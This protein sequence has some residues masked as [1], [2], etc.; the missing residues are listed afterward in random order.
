MRAVNGIH[1]EWVEDEA[2]VLDPSTGQL[3]YLNPP[4]AVFLGLV[5][6]YGYEQGLS[7]FRQTYSHE[8][9]FDEELAEMIE[10]MRDGGLL[11]DD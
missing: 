7:E 4:A 5:L 1:V 10:Q 8:P 11:V 9:N 2:V 6:E 3:H